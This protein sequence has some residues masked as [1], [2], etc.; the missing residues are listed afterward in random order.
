MNAGT[1]NLFVLKTSFK[2]AKKQREQDPS[3]KQLSE[4]ETKS[5]N[6]DIAAFCFLTLL[7]ALLLFAVLFKDQVIHFLVANFS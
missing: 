1:E 6:G 4:K 2:I 7:V 5:K 3:E